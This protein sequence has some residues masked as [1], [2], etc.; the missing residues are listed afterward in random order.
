MLA[1]RF[2]SYSRRSTFAGDAVLV[3]PEID[4]AVVLLVAAALVAHGD[5]A[6]VVAADRACLRSMSAA[7]GAPL[8]RSGVDDPDQPRR[9]GE[10]GFDFDQCHLIAPLGSGLGREVDFLAF[11]QAHVRLSSSCA[12][13]PA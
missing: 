8:C 4:D 2:G 9:P 12:W 1:L 13:R 10:V 5:V 11:G 7:N 6:V 3:A